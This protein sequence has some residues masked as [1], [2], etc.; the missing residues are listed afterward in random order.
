MPRNGDDARRRLQQAAL[1]LVQEHG[2]DATTSAEI[3]ARAGLTE[4]TFFRHFSDKRE[5]LFEEDPRLR[6]A[7]TEAMAEAAQG[8]PPLEIVLQA[9]RSVGPRLEENRAFTAPRQPIIAATPALRERADAKTAALIS[10]LA[11]GLRQRGVEAKLAALAAQ[12]GMAAFSYAARAWFEDP[13][14]T[15]DVHL[16]QAFQALNRMSP[17]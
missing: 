5:A 11:A 9:L 6:P 7:L 4:R 10:L 8:L 17:G 14:E 2:Y 12:V 3:A 1:E 16:T 15:F 13:T